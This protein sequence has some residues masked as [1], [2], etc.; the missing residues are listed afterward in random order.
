MPGAQKQLRRRIQ[1]E[2]HR[3]LTN[4]ERSSESHTPI[5]SGYGLQFGF[6]IGLRRSNEMNSSQVLPIVSK[7]PMRPEARS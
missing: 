4:L 1:A 3:A 2:P 7:T 5:V 6:S